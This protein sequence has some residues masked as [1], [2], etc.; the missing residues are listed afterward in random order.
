[1]DDEIRSV[2]K[3][4]DNY[5][6]V[7]FIANCSYIIKD[8]DKIMDDLIWGFRMVAT[9]GESENGDFKKRI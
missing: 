2:M 5:L 4:G 1:M 3:K 7:V 6:N 9:C 8:P